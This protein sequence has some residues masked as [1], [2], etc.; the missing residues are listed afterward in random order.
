LRLVLPPQ[1]SPIHEAAAAALRSAGRPFDIVC[2]SAD[3]AVRSAA[4][5]AG[6]GIAPMIDGLQPGG[7]TRS[8]DPTLPALPPLVISLVAR[9]EALAVAC[10]RWVAAEVVSAFQAL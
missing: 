4:V 1:G 9:S 5:A 7:L 8:A 3:F 10:Q 6:L 2:A